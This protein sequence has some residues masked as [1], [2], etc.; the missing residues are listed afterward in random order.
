M[1][2]LYRRKKLFEKRRREGFEQEKKYVLKRNNDI[3]DE[4]YINVFDV[5][6]NPMFYTKNILEAIEQNT[7]ASTESSVFLDIGCKTGKMVQLLQEQGYSAFGVEPQEAMI[8][9]LEKKNP[10]VAESCMRGNTTDAMLYE[11]DSFSHVLVLHDTIYK[12]E[13]KVAFFRNC[14]F[15]LKSGGHLILRLFHPLTPILL[16]SATPAPTTAT[17]SAGCKAKAKKQKEYPT[18]QFQSSFQWLNPEK[19]EILY[20]EKFTDKATLNI[21]ENESI[22]FAPDADE[23]VKEAIFCRFQL[24]GNI[25]LSPTTTTNQ[26]VE[27]QLY[28]FVRMN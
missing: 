15:W 16:A 21:R 12:I 2:Q 23:I 8:Q 1:I 25:R 17:K 11:R 22:L 3:Y 18:F 26:N 20:T 19:K 7:Q 6:Y 27:H 4:Y 10:V 13:D 9:Y 24:V 5:V 28:I 14:Y